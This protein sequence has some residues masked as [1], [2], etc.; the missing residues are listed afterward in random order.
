VASRVG[1]IFGMDGT[2]NR[3]R[4]VALGIVG[5]IFVLTSSSA[6]A[7]DLRSDLRFWLT[8]DSLSGHQDGEGVS[9][10]KDLSGNGLDV[11][12]P[13]PE[14]QPVFKT[15]VLNGRPSVY[16]GGRNVLARES[17][18][19][20]ALVSTRSV[21]FYIVLRQIGVNHWYGCD[22]P[23]S[24]GDNPSRMVLH[25]TLNGT[26]Y[27]QHGWADHCV[28]SWSPPPTWKDRF[29]LLEVFRSEGTFECVVDGIQLDRTDGVCKE[30]GPDLF[31]VSQID[32]GEDPFSNYPYGYFFLGD[33][34]E[35]LIYSR[36][37]GASERELVTAYLQSKWFGASLPSS[38]PDI[39]GD[40]I[41][42]AFDNCPTN[43]NPDQADSDSDG[44]G[45]ACVFSIPP[46]RLLHVHS[47]PVAKLPLP[48]PTRKS[49]TTSTSIETA[50]P[51]QTSS[52]AT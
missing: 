7:A 38:V 11:E 30:T 15:N 39:D 6:R 23:F 41:T 36:A 40:G 29:H 20:S 8:A 34:C 19:G 22:A 24:W 51:P 18:P 32:I 44:I 14:L 26:I 37:L 52:G 21:T 4:I 49:T 9:E 1:G 17:V 13:T 31:E 10:W 50:P 42:D 2:M 28:P 25:A 43:A 46:P 33:I 48:G 5:I 16:F 35:I 12:M 47:H 27:F 3:L 45:D